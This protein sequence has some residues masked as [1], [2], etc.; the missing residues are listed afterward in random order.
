M[1]PPPSP[2]PG[3]I[4]SFSPESEFS[5]AKLGWWKG[6]QTINP[7]V[8]LLVA[9]AT[10]T[11]VSVYGVLSGLAPSVNL[12]CVVAETSCA[13]LVQL[14]GQGITAVAGSDGAVILEGALGSALT[15]SSAQV[16]ARSG[17]AGVYD[18]AGKLLMC[19]QLRVVANTQVV[20]IGRM[21]AQFNQRTAQG[22]AILRR[23]A[24]MGNSEMHM[25]GILFGLESEFHGMWHFHRG[26]NCLAAT[27][28]VNFYKGIYASYETGRTSVRGGDPWTYGNY[29]RPHV[30]MWSNPTPNLHPSPNLNPPPNLNSGLTSSTTLTLTLTSARIPVGLR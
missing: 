19:T 22:L 21:P 27:E 16:L 7:N 17:F 4:A 24:V 2:P 15:A 11:T 26:F 23:E 30:V 20:L 9:Q 29:V 28:D 8:G 25:T 5:T 6:G 14:A 13:D 3:L 10:G 18:S 12:T 1:P